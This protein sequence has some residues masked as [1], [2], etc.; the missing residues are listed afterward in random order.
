MVNRLYALLVLALAFNTLGCEVLRGDAPSPSPNLSSDGL[1]VRGIVLA[2]IDDDEDDDSSND[3]ARGFGTPHSDRALDT[4]GGLG[5]EW[6]SLSVY[7]LL[8]H[9]CDTSITP[10]WDSPGQETAA[11]VREQIAQAKARGVGVLLSPTLYV[12]DGW[13]GELGQCDEET[14]W[15]ASQWE[16]FWESYD[17]YI[18]TWVEL[19]EQEQV[20]IVSL[21]L[22]LKSIT[23]SPTQQARFKSLIA[24]SRSAYSGLL[25]YSANWDELEQVTF[26]ESLDFV[27]VNAFF[28]LLDEEQLNATPKQLNQGAQQI[29]LYLA[30]LQP[31]WGRPILFTEVGYK[32]HADAAIEPWQWP[33]D[34]QTQGVDEAYQAAA[35]E[36][37]MQAFWDQP[38]F[39]GMFWWK[40][41]TDINDATQTNFPAQEGPWGFS[42]IDKQAQDIVSTWYAKPSP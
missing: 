4:L 28:P 19:A 12:L 21:G 41:F 1:R 8:D 37:I 24:T 7:G 2:H 29:A 38:W 16:A 25:T 3:G 9:T 15:T 33:E 20:D 36:A 26:W 13:R 14:Q 17:V 10:E 5:V 39:A 40:S 22:E 27:G 31:Q 11:S 32:S 6:V 30:Q 42:P 18:S 23:A 34:V 35:Y